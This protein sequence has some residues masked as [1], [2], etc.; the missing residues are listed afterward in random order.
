MLGRHH[1]IFYLLRNNFKE[2]LQKWYR[3]FL[4]TLYLVFHDINI[5]HYH[6]RT[7]KQDPGIVAHTCYPSYSGGRGRRITRLRPTRAKVRKALSQNKIKTKKLRH[8]LSGNACVW[9]A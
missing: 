9:K 2:N 7:I 6:S 8:G 5:F 4:Y 3:E 1:T